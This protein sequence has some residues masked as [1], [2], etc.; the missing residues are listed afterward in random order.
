MKMNFF[1]INRPPTQQEAKEWLQNYLGGSLVR[2][3]SMSKDG[4]T[5]KVIVSTAKGDR[6]FSISLPLILDNICR[7]QRKNQ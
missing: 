6:E 2:L 3:L 4:R 5:A 7:I 1:K